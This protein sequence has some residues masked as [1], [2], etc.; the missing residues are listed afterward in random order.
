MSS[1]ASLLSM[2]TQVGNQTALEVPADLN[3]TGRKLLV[4]HPCRGGLTLWFQQV[5]DVELP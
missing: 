5:L 2:R 1:L 4:F 3:L